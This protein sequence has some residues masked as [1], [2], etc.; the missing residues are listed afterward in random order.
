MPLG[1]PPP[2]RVSRTRGLA[3]SA[4]FAALT[5]ATAGLAIP[6]FV[7]PVPVTVQVFFI[8]L[9][10]A[11]GGPWYGGL[12]LLIYVMLGAAGLPIFAGYN[13]GIP[14]LVGPS[15]GYL[16]A[17]P[18]AGLAIGWVAGRRSPSRREWIRVVSGMI[19]GLALIYAAGI[20]WLSV[21][22][23]LDLFQAF[24]IGGAVFIPVDLLKLV[25]AAPIA[26]RLRSLMPSLPIAREHNRP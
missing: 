2:A 13:G 9:A 17:Y 6:I 11:L 4:L 25:V 19:L 15:G 8:Y 26:V 5:G 7:T 22:L 3:F 16:F 12:S 14:V 18:L 24:L 10:G 1:E 20:I 21:Y 23:R